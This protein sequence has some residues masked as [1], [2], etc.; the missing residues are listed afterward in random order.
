M[1]T[2]YKSVWLQLV[3]SSVLLVLLSLSLSAHAHRLRPAVVTAEFNGAGQLLLTINANFEQ[4]IAGIEP[5][6]QDTSEAPQAQRY[7]ELRELSAPQ[8][9]TEVSKFIDDYLGALSVQFDSANADL[10]I[11]KITVPENIDKDRARITEVVL[12]TTVPP[13][14]GTFVWQY[15]AA[16]GSSVLRIAVLGEPP[17]RAQWLADGKPSEAF[18]V[19][20]P[21]R[22]RTTA[23]VALDYIWLGLTH[24][25]PLGADHVLFVLGIFLL[26]VQLRPLLWQVTAF[27]VAH[28]I[29]LTLALFGVVQLPGSIVEPLIA[30][31]IAYVGIENVLVKSLKPWRVVV[32]F[33]FGLLHGLGFA[34]VLTSLGLPAGET[35]TALIAFNVGVELGQLTVIAAALL[36]GVYWIRNKTWFRSRVVIPGSLLISAVGVYWTIERVLASA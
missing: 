27:T 14:A 31:S 32:V 11:S 29:T 19:G 30:L 9:H 17:T 3:T 12:Q 25:V 7:I 26:S 24:I 36:A 22:A 6:H 15:P 10:V 21:L 23:A 33:A 35:V 5:K 8:F 4:L 2:T 1:S 34:G 28:S 16:F 18:Q 20:E 13:D